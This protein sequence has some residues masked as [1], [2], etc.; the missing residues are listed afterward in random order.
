MSWII[1][2]STVGGGSGGSLQDAY[3]SSAPP[4]ITTSAGL[5][6]LI[7]RQGSGLDTDVVVDVQ[8]GAGSSTLAI[9]GDGTLIL[10][11]VS[12]IGIKFDPAAPT[13][14]WK[15]VLGAIVVR[16][17]G[18]SAPNFTTFRGGSCR[19]YAFDVGDQADIIFHIPHDY[20]LGSDL[21]LHL[22][23]LHNGTSVSG[24][25]TVD[26]S[27]SYAK[28]HDQAAFSAEVTPQLTVA[29]PNIATIPRWQHR[30]DEIQL[31]AVVPAADQLTTGDLEVDGIISINLS[32][33]VIPAISGGSPNQPFFLFADLHYQSTGV[34]TKNKVPNFY[35]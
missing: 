33:S 27:V 26:Y 18:P 15:D 12:G 17:T 20:V 34:A 24:N 5:Q 29:A 2:G 23:W 32:P 30:I 21:H 28:G 25:L 10:D 3:N 14:G 13:Y 6:A 11:N 9:T 22:H 1:L 31:S 8:D 35:T 19:A 7:L 4:L 16:Q